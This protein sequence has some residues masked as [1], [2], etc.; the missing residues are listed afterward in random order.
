MRMK[1]FIWIALA[2]SLALAPFAG[3]ADPPDPLGQEAR[4]ILQAHCAS[5]HGG[6]KAVKGGFGFV[7][8]RERLVSRQLVVPGKASA[9]DLLLRMQ[10]GEMP[11]PA[12][13]PRPSPAELKTIERWIDAGAPA[14]DRPAS[15]VRVLSPAEAIDA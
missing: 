14:F 6:G 15:A 3:A 12:K 10:Q 1:N 9:S 7:L 11:P 5:C 2:W 8:D 4:Q 13:M